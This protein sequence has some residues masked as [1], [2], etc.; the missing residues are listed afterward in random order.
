[1]HRRGCRSTGSGGRLVA[2]LRDHRCPVG[3][4][5]GRAPQTAYDGARRD[6]RARAGAAAG[7]PGRRTRSRAPA[8][9]RGLPGAGERARRRRR[10]HQ[11]LQH[12][13]DRDGRRLSRG[14]LHLAG[15]G[16]DATAAAGAGS[17]GAAHPV[18]ELAVAVG[19]VRG[20]AGTGGQPGPVG[21][22]RRRQD[23]HPRR[24][25]AAIGGSRLPRDRTG[26]RRAVDQRHRRPVAA[27]GGGRARHPGGG[28]LRH[29]DG[30]R[31]T[32]R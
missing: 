9:Q 6:A 20:R 23:Q 11:G 13:G 32:P 17:T 26:R 10:L 29:V 22:D 21:T 30:T 5:N 18:V 16:R 12:H 31:A 1:M 25:V 4:P 15:G 3:G 14:D 28:R 24:R 27:A 2:G 19:P 8:G 7:G